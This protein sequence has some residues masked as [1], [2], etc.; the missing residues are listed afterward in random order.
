MRLTSTPG[1][2]G[3]SLDSRTPS[4]RLVDA[5]GNAALSGMTRNMSSQPYCHICDRPFDPVRSY[6]RKGSWT[7]L[8]CPV[9]RL[10]MLHPVPDDSVLRSYYNG[11][12]AVKFD[13]YMKDIR[14][15]ASAVLADLN[16]Q[17]PKRGRLLEIGCSYGGFLREA[18]REGWDVTGIELSETAAQ[19]AREQ[20]GLKVFCGELQDQIDKLGEPYDVVALFHVIEHVPDPIGFLELSRKL[21]TPGGILLLKTPN[22]TSLI[23]RITGKTWQWVSPPAHLWLY[24]PGTLK[25][26]LMRAG[27]RLQ[28][29]RSSQ[30]DANN[31]LFALISGVAKRVLA[32]THGESLSDLRKS[33]GV[34]V[35][36]GTCETVYRPL[37]LLMDPWLGRRLWQPELYAVAS[38]GL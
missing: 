35:L 25:L 4:P 30:G 34:R 3:R 33:W 16:R 2:S 20:F 27:Y 7:Y 26:L 29:C 10:V 21:T 31:N 12:Y 8:R 37:R 9:C 28:Y 1:S 11:S 23:A 5:T 17:F 6:A 15:G 32:R 14:R 38:N 22:V 36:E 13:K 18:Q 24:S 19:F